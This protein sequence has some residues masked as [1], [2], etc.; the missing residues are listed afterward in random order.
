MSADTSDV[1]VIGAGIVGAACARAFALEGLSVALVESDT[2]G[3]GATATGMGHVVVMDDSPAQFALTRYS[4]RLWCE[5][6]EQLPDECEYGTCGTIWIAADDEEMET[7]RRKREYYRRHGVQAEMLDAAAL[8]EAEPNLRGG[9]P[10]GLR[11][12]ADLA[13]FPPAAASWMVDTARQHGARLRLG[14]EAVEI[15]GRGVRLGDGSLLSGAA[16][17]N[18][19]GTLAG[20]LTPGVDVQPRKGHLVITDR[21]PGFVNHELIEL[22][23]LKSAHRATVDSVA[24]NVQPRT[25]GQ[26]LIGSSRQYG[27]GGREVEI[28]ILGRMVGRALEYL[29]PLARVSAIRTW[30]GFRAATGDKLPLIGRCPGSQRVYLATGH[31]GLGITMSLGTA[32]LLVDQVM[33]RKSKIPHEPYLPDRKMGS[34]LVSAVP[35]TDDG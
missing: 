32:A 4:Q 20:R 11:V 30:T 7:V 6:V 25:T 31:E 22:G 19:T 13:V 17:I 23:Y 34:G 2:I 8:A 15:A 5:I 28:P 12:P 24:L 10:G 3:G 14:V 33:G 26:L 1:I 18:A 9:L 27:A 29:P 21:Y 35:D 16:T